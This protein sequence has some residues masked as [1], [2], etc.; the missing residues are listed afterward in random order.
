MQNLTNLVFFLD[1]A[2]KLEVYLEKKKK[3]MIVRLE[4]C[5]LMAIF[6]KNV[7]CIVVF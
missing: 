2:A 4:S 7:G 1:I 3:K 6:D 5:K